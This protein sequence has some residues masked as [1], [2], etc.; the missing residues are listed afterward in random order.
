MSNYSATHVLFDLLHARLQQQINTKFCTLQN[1]IHSQLNKS[2]IISEVV[3]VHSCRQQTSNARHLSRKSK[4]ANDECLAW[5][6][7]VRVVNNLK[8]KLKE[9]I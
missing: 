2:E 6:K 4:Y 8:K 3:T 1:S 5:R 7:N 9:K